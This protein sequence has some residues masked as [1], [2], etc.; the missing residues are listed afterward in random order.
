MSYETPLHKVYGMGSAHSGVRNFAY[1]RVTALVLIPLSLWFA[2]TVIGLSGVSEVTVLIYLS[3][4]LHAILMALFVFMVLF[5]LS[6]G[7]REVITD[8]VPHGG[9]KLILIMASAGFA[10]VVAIFCFFCLLRIA[11]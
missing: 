4:P 10:A 2:A 1:Q 8:Y 9:V 11:L 5:H 7:L 3:N 6:L